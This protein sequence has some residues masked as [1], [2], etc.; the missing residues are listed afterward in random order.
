MREWC[1]V[2]DAVS[3][4]AADRIGLALRDQQLDL[5]VEDREARVLCFSDGE[6]EVRRLAGEIRHR[7]LQAS[8][9]DG[10]VRSGHLLVWSEP[11]H[12][13]VDP[14]HPDEGLYC[15]DLD[16]GEIRWR[17]RL[18]LAS[19]LE[20][21]RVRKALPRL[22]ARVI[23]S[24]PRHLDLGAT[25]RSDADEIAR[26]VRTLDGWPRLH[27]L[28]SGGWNVG[29]SV[30]A[31]PATTRC[32]PLTAHGA[33]DLEAP[34]RTFGQSVLPVLGLF[35]ALL[36]GAA[37]LFAMYVL[38]SAGSFEGLSTLGQVFLLAGPAMAVVG[39]VLVRRGT[40]TPSYVPGSED[41]RAG[42]VY[43]MGH[44]SVLAMNVFAPLLA[45]VGLIAGPLFLV[46]G[47]WE[48]VTGPGFGDRVGGL[49]LIPFGIGG[50]YLAVWMGRGT[51]Q[52]FQLRHHQDP[53]FNVDDHGI[54]CA[55]GRF[56]WR[57]IDRVVE[58]LDPVGDD[59]KLRSLIFRLHEGATPQ[60]VERAYLDRMDNDLIGAA[61]LT[62][63]GLELTIGNCAKQASSALSGC[64][65]TPEKAER[66]ELSTSPA[67]AP[68][69]S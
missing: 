65:H 61:S 1:L 10:T 30:N 28:S 40:R 58:V 64:G 47:L 18:E 43:A 44:R 12:R 26:A 66:E 31:R 9:W 67:V 27:R 50:I 54:E 16:L 29:G 36:G 11:L 57:D 48:L 63:Y 19:V 8:L 25:D 59:R 53:Y 34:M 23:G 56:S 35:M 37:F 33:L 39:V 17:V 13:Y 42:D 46:G 32:N 49:F 52:F 51:I 24:G 20:S 55:R 21:R 45:L 6:T 3:A 4:E 62:E 60:P 15:S 41:S 38:V 2:I 7:L 69:S 14:E 5:E 22:Q 68:S